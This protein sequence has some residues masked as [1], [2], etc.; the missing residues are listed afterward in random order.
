LHSPAAH[1]CKLE[2]TCNVIEC[3][4]TFQE[5]FICYPA[6]EEEDNDSKFVSRSSLFT[7]EFVNVI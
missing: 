5:P 2:D 6:N 7:K 3:E 1:W 4:D